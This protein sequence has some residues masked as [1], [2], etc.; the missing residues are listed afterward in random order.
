ML[1]KYILELDRKLC[2]ERDVVVIKDLVVVGIWTGLVELS[3][4]VKEMM[5]TNEE[6]VVQLVLVERIALGAHVHAKLFF[7]Q[8]TLSILVEDL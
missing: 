6:H 1:I 3:K 5:K 7:S 4:R 8:V 2:E